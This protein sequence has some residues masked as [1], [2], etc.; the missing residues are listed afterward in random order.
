MPRQRIVP[1]MDC[2]WCGRCSSNTRKTLVHGWSTTNTS[3]VR[4]CWWRRC[5]TRA[6]RVAR[7]ICRPEPGLIIKAARVIPAAGSRSKAA[8][9]QV[10]LPGDSEIHEVTL[11]RQAG[12]F[13]LDT[14]PLAGRVTWNISAA[15]DAK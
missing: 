12:E 1:N 2:R 13:K 9:G 15:G 11:T 3:T 6:R 5:Y 4:A 7:C 8:K 14:D 10:F